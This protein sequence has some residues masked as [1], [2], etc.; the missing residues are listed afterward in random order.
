[1]VCNHID[2]TMF[3]WLVFNVPKI[4]NRNGFKILYNGIL[5]IKGQKNNFKELQLWIP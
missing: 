3:I 4:G 5:R 2:G 1:M